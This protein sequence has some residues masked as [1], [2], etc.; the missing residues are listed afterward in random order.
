M[1]PVHQMSKNHRQEQRMDVRQ[2]RV[3]NTGS[4]S[5]CVKVD[6]QGVPVRGIIDSGSDLCRCW[7]LDPYQISSGGE[8]E[9]P[10]AV[11]TMAWTI[12]SGQ[13]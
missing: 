5:H 4:H 2:V 8:W 13:P 10:E 3:E 7:R 12:S 6:I 9:E 1:R 11:P